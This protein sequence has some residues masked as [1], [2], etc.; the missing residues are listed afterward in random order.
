MRERGIR[1]DVEK[2]AKLQSEFV[3]Q[4]KLKTISYKKN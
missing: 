1:V 2:A 4:E 3:A